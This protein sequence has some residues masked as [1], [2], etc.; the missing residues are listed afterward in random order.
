MTYCKS[1]QTPMDNRLKLSKKGGGSAVNETEY[2][3]LVG[4]L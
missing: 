2:L 3:S 4:S 1:C